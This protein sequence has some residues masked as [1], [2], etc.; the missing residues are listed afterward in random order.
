MSKR[1]SRRRKS[2]GVLAGKKGYSERSVSCCL[3]RK[4]ISEWWHLVRNSL[5]RTLSQ[6]E[7]KDI[8]VSD[9]FQRSDGA[10]GLLRDIS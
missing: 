6:G 7:W 3:D 1:K 2:F 9:S 4:K 10:D 8:L 5:K